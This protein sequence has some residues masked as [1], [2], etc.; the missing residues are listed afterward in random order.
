MWRRHSGRNAFSAPSPYTEPIALEIATVLASSAPAAALNSA[1]RPPSAALVAAPARWTC[2][3]KRLLSPARSCAALVLEVIAIGDAI[4][5]CAGACAVDCV[6]PASI[7]PCPGSAGA[8]RREH[9]SLF[10]PHRWTTG[11]EALWMLRA[12]SPS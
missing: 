6:H 11:E 3:E 12:I 4:V 9:P 10:P 1:S 7:A 8:D 5:P 2:S